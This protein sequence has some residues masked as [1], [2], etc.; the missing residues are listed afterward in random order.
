MIKACEVRVDR[1]NLSTHLTKLDQNKAWIDIFGM[2]PQAGKLWRNPLRNDKKAGCSFFVNSQGVVIFNDFAEGK[3]YNIVDMLKASRN[4]SLYAALEALGDNIL[5]NPITYSSSKK[6]LV[7]VKINGFSEKEL[8][9]WASYGITPD[10]LKLF[11]VFSVSHVYVDKKL[12]KRST[13]NNPIFAYYYP[14]ST[15]VKTYRPLTKIP[16]DKWLGNA[17]QDDINGWDQIPYFGEQLVVTKS[18]KDVMTLYELGI[19]SVAPQGEGMDIPINILQSY[20]NKIVILYDN[21]GD[22]AT[23]NSPGSKGKGFAQRLSR[24]YNVPMCFIPDGEPKD[25]SDYYNKW[26][27]EKTLWLLS[28]LGLATHTSS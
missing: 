2:D 5:E 20:Y 24:K 3:K 11:N 15:N 19:I 4:I 13:K 1:A 27:K 8:E 17:T 6:K 16:E 25:I 21:D 23:S 14:Y 18:L 28:E 22:F 12:K 7:Q 10:T 9:Y 26:G